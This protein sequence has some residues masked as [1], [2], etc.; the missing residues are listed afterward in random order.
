LTTTTTTTT[1]QGFDSKYGGFDG[2]RGIKFP[3]PSRLF[4]LNRVHALFGSESDVGSKALQ[5]SLHTL[6]C[7]VAGG[8]NDH[9]AG[10]FARYIYYIQYTTILSCAAHT[11]VIVELSSVYLMIQEVHA[12]N[13]AA[14]YVH[15]D[16]VCM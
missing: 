16:I 7:M 15:A 13:N 9:I 1:M 2:A 12:R 10:G 14:S 3:Q 4:F 8:I 6:D 11:I 5:M